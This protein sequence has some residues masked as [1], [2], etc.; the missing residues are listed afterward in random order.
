MLG[1]VKL[2]LRKMFV[3]FLVGFAPVLTLALTTV[4]DVLGA[5]DPDYAAL[6]RAFGLALLVG[7]G[8]ALA[9]AII[10]VLPFN[11]TPGDAVHGPGAADSVTMTK[12]GEVQELHS[13]G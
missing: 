2:L 5:T 9:R 4:I 12:S 7:A 13:P 1:P 3:A 6:G 10:A 11:L 8:S